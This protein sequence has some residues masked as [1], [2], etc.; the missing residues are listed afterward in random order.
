MI[1]KNKQLLFQ[2]QAEVIKALAHPL[3]IA[4]LDFLGDGE[5]C[6][7]DIAEHIDAE[8]SNVSR[9]LALMVNAGILSFHKDGLKVIY[10]LKAPCLL[11]FFGCVTQVIEEQ[12]KQ[13]QQM[14]RA[15]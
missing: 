14:F 6:V 7:C 9:H 11:A 10:A 2:K 1:E 4:I 13:D 12:H 8:R 5:Q 15:V 3:R